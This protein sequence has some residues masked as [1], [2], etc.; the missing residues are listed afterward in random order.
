MGGI[1]AGALAGSLV[2]SVRMPLQHRMTKTILFTLTTF[3][4]G[5]AGIGFTRQQPAVFALLVMC[6]AS[7]VICVALCNTTIQ[8]RIPDALRGRV[9]SMYTFAFSGFLPFGTLFGGI[10]AEHRGFQPTMAMLG[11]GLLLTAAIAAPIALR[12]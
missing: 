1:G 9:L 4:I 7:M 8:Q 12:E 6:G 2:L 3:G 11:G 10:L 5:L